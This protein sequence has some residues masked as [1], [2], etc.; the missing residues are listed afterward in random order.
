L[1]PFFVIKNNLNNPLDLIYIFSSGLNGSEPNLVINGAV[2]TQR[3]IK[4][5]EISFN[6]LFGLLFIV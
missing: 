2:T 4:P 5:I 3:M 1:F 6:K